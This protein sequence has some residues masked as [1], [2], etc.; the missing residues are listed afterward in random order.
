MHNVCYRMEGYAVPPRPRFSREEIVDA[1]LEL[2]SERG[3]GAL[4]SRELGARL[5]SSARP[6]FTVFGSMEELEQEVRRAAMRRFNEF[7][8][9]ARDELPAFKRLGMQTVR[10][11]LAEPRL[12]QLLFMV[13]NERARSFD[14]VFATLGDTATAAVAMLEE[15]YALSRDEAMGLFKQMWI[16]TFG[17]GALCAARVCRF[18]EEEISDM[19]SR[20]FRGATA[21]ARSRDIDKE[22]K[23]SE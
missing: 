19:L 2:V 20:A 22:G 21:L 15:E 6:I 17:I 1:A 11:A 10:F 12:Y 7:A 13:E 9:S 16:F 8:L 4:T 5:G 18:S 14:D 3:V 23:C